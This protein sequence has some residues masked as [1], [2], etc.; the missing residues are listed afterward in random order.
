MMPTMYRLA[1]LLSGLDSELFFR[2]SS[3]IRHCVTEFKCGHVRPWPKWAM[4]QSGQCSTPECFNGQCP[5]ICGSSQARHG[6]CVILLSAS[7]S[8]R[9]ELE[10]ESTVN[11]SPSMLT[12][13]KGVPFKDHCQHARPGAICWEKTHTGISL[14]SINTPGSATL[15]WRS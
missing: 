3:M 4:P 13:L 1:I 9:V 6:C 11:G 15:R 12:R 8:V 14:T 7:L 5:S 2:A 10:R